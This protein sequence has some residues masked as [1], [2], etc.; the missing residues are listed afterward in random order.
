MLTASQFDALVDPIVSLY[1]DYTDSVIRDIARRL[2]GM[3]MTATAAWQMQRLTESGKVYENA[4][5]ELSKL[6][7]RSETELRLAFEKAG[8][9]AL[10]FDDA[11]YREAGPN[12]LP[13]NLS[14]SM[15]EVLKVGLAKTQGIMQNLTT[16][17]AISGQQTFLDA[18]DRAYMQVSS[19]AFSYDQAIRAAVKD[20]ATNGLNVINY[21]SRTDQLDVAVRRA[22]LTGVGQTTGQLQWARADEMG[23]DLVQTTAHAGARPSH[24]VWQG[25]IFSR[26]GKSDKYPDFVKS[27][28]Y[29]TAGGLQG[30]NCRHSFYAYYEGISE[31]AYDQATLDEFAD[32]TVTYQGQEMSVYEASQAQRGIERKIRYWKRQA[33]A[34][35]V[36][37]QDSTEETAKVQAWQ[38]QMRRFVKE[39]KLV[40]QREREQA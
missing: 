34:L 10:R 28:G 21:A 4:L 1:Q 8:V 29:G 30:I 31:N 7:G 40:R 5:E 33:G 6:T 38:A 22:V 16:T 17:T 20:V 24:A 15:I 27:T 26:S 18:A 11:I 35:E 2:A 23:C 36:A 37:G 19:G 14:P 25:Q 12:P 32:R 9:R 39:T 3:D 13:L